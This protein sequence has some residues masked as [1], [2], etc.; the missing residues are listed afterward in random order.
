MS[1][2]TGTREIHVSLVGP[3][4]EARGFVMPVGSSLADLLRVGEVDAGMARVTIDGRTPE[5]AL[6][7]PPGAVVSVTPKVSGP[8][9]ARGWRDL[10]GGF[11]DDP[12]FDEMMRVV[13]AEREAEKDRS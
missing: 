3:D 12:A 1:I 4:G 5:E 7:L 13:E 9:P 6:I 11:A 2:H 8:E 10:M